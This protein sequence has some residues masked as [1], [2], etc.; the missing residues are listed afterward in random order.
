MVMLCVLVN[1]DLLEFVVFHLWVVSDVLSDMR[2]FIDVFPL[3]SWMPLIMFMLGTFPF[4]ESCLLMKYVICPLIVCYLILI[5]TMPLC[6]G[7]ILR[8]DLTILIVAFCS[9]FLV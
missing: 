9:Q 4:V 1:L 3:M 6:L 7:D 2:I 8:V 5:G